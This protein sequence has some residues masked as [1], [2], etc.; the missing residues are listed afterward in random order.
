MPIP[1]VTNPYAA[2]TRTYAAS[3][4][5]LSADLNAIQDGIIA[6]GAAVSALVTSVNDYMQEARTAS[7]NT[8]DA[9]APSNGGSKAVWVEKNTNDTTEVVLDNT[10][11]WKDRYIVITGYS[12]AVAADNPGGAS[13]NALTI[14]LGNNT[15]G[16]FRVFYS[17]DGQ[18]GTSA[19]EAC[20]HLVA[21][22]Q[23]LRFYVNNTTG[24]LC[25]KRTDVGTSYWFRG[26]IRCSP[27]QGHYA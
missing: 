4:Q 3:N 6:V 26:E 22:G 14:D 13:D 11:N 19:L 5:V 16:I 10:I 12:N 15:T 24:N 17:R 18:D 21:A 27:D 8:T 23:T 2:R 1:A 25:F 20:E 9:P 7:C